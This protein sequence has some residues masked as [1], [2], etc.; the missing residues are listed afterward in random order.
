M[1]TTSN[2]RVHGPYLGFGTLAINLMDVMDDIVSLKS[3]ELQSH[4]VGDRRQSVASDDAVTDGENPTGRTTVVTTP[5]EPEFTLEQVVASGYQFH[6]LH[7]CLY[8]NEHARPGSSASNSHGNNSTTPAHGNAPPSV[9]IRA[10]HD[11]PHTTVAQ[12]IETTKW[13]DSPVS[14]HT[15]PHGPLD[16]L[17]PIPTKFWKKKA[18]LTLQPLTPLDQLIAIIVPAPKGNDLSHYDNLALNEGFSLSANEDVRGFSRL[19]ERNV[20]S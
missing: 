14:P 3:W 19:S 6:K 9:S 10:V 4:G 11:V 8:F 20:M 1:M 16:A 15:A 18:F 12:S 5:E 13:T 2:H 17:P 7:D